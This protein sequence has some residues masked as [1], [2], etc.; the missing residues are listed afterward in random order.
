[1]N[2]MINNCQTCCTYA[3]LKV[4]IRTID[5]VQCSSD[6]ANLG[7]GQIDAPNPKSETSKVG[8]RLH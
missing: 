1:M 8:E 5:L 2:V 4:V 6:Y 3:S 7:F